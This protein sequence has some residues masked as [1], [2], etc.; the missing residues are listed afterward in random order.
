MGL[1]IGESKPT[2]LPDNTNLSPIDQLELFGLLK[3]TEI[4]AKIAR[5]VLQDFQF[6]Y[7]R[8]N[9]SE[10]DFP[11][12]EPFWNDKFIKRLSD[13]E[14]QL[15][16]THVYTMARLK[17]FPNEPSS[18]PGGQSVMLRNQNAEQRD[19]LARQ[20]TEYTSGLN[21]LASKPV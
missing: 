14:A 21:I 2:F 9:Y 6:K 5:Y 4:S 3:P 16:L 11:I 7:T 20:F 10:S 18:K 12:K 8:L 19:S 17:H 15:A 13:L 1:A